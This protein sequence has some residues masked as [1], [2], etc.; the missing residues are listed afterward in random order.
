MTPVLLVL[1][2]GLVGGLVLW[3]GWY[4]AKKRREL[5]QGFALSQGWVWTAEDD[6]WTE[7]FSG[8]PFGEGDHRRACNV[9]TGSFRGRPLTAFDYSYQTHSTDSKG[10]RTT[11]THRYAICALALPAPLPTFE[12]VPEG[13]LGRVGTVLGMQDIE[14]ESEDFNRRFRVRCEDAKLAYDLLPARTMQAL[15]TRP[16]L[17][18][19]LR[20]ADAVCWEGGSHSPSELLARLDALSTLIDGVPAYVWS[21]RKDPAP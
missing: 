13:F 4:T 10:N 21:D 9:L 16:A 12:L 15:L 20:A 11:T 6:R 17:H 19:R 7:R 2:V 3:Y 5:F 14:L 18:V 8:D 1:G